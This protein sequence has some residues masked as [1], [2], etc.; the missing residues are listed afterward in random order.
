VLAH[1]PEVLPFTAA[2]AEQA[3]SFGPAGILGADA[4]HLAAAVEAGADYF[5]TT[6]DKLLR[7]SAKVE[8][9]GVSVASPLELA[10]YLE[11]P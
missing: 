10:A 11:Q 7:R 8:T 9:G 1:A 3:R 2:M 6:D 5:C 4:L